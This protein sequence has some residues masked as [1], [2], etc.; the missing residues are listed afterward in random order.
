MYILQ[1][2][3]TTTL[4]QKDIPWCWKCMKKV[5]KNT[6]KQWKVVWIR[7]YRRG[8][9][10]GWLGFGGCNV[11]QVLDH[12]LGVLGLA[13]SRLTS[14]ENT[15]IFAICKKKRVVLLI[16]RATSQYSKTTSFKSIRRRGRVSFNLHPTTWRH[17]TVSVCCSRDWLVVVT[18]AMDSLK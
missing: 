16:K 9:V 2:S 10:W 11:S 8:R 15:L 14:A 4:V 5:Q 7:S 18:L 12:F 3:H 13:G 1:S 6:S 17:A